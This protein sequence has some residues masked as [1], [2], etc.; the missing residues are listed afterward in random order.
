MKF[1]ILVLALI[2]ILFSGCKAEY[3][4]NISESGFD[5]DANAYIDDLSLL[6]A[7]FD[8]VST[9]K[10]V[11]DNLSSS[12]KT[13]IYH[14]PNFNIYAENPQ[15]GVT[16]Y[17]TSLI[18]SNGRYGAN[19]KHSFTME[20]YFESGIINECTT[21]EVSKKGSIYTLNSGILDNCFKNYDKLTDLTINI[22]TDYNL[23]SSNANSS[24][25]NTYTWHFTR[26]NYIGKNIRFVFN[27][28]DNSYPEEILPSDNPNTD[29]EES[30]NPKEN[31]SSS[32]EPINYSLIII[33]SSIFLGAIL[34]FAI[35]LY[36]KNKKTKKI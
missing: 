18:N 32:K 29:K 12:Y 4:L 19:F 30:E 23:V 28:V 24:L 20:D 7:D 33:I 8:G 2:I 21:L 26:D 13:V 5:E 36:F 25:N 34:V 16:Y 27:T 17:N 6:S 11:F 9:Y 22:T 35:Y 1:K 10:E 15:T 14:D 31:P 3:N